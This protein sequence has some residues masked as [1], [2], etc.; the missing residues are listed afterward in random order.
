MKA[1]VTIDLE[2]DGLGTDEQ[3]SARVIASDAFKLAVDKL[4]VFGVVS[5]AFVRNGVSITLGR[6]ETGLAY[7]GALAAAFEVEQEVIGAFRLAKRAAQ[8]EIPTDPRLPVAP[9]PASSP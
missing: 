2:V 3:V 6:V 1:S 4:R 8:D 5:V 7:R 9:D